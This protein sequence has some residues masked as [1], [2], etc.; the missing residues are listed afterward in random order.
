MVFNERGIGKMRKIYLASESKRRMQLLKNLR[1]KFSVI[2]PRTF[3]IMEMKAPEKLS[4][5]NASK[6]A[7]SVV[8]LVPEN[9]CIIAADTI[10]V[11]NGRVL[12][13][14]RNVL[15]ARKMLGELSGRWHEVI[16]GLSVVLL[17]ERK[18][19][20]DA[21]KTRVKF[22]QLTDKELEFYIATK[23][24]LDKAGAYGIQGY[25]SMFIERIEGCYFN[26]VGLPINALYNL[27]MKVGVNLLEYIE[28]RS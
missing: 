13:K 19:V 24:P 5:E 18:E 20:N 2:K 21:V 17:P 25:A 14:P 28:M 1:I 10:V 15:E 27:M 8:S 6:K 3:E 9:A 11:L 4:I 16:T 23:E 12:G 7:W 26:V 22:K